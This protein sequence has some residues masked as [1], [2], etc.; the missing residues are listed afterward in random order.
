MFY[1]HLHC[2]YKSSYCS[3]IKDPVVSRNAEWDL[4]DWFPLVFQI[5]FF[6]MNISWNFLSFSNCNNCCLWT[7]NS[8]NKIST[9]NVPYD[10]NWKC[11]VSKITFN[12]FFFSDLYCK[13]FKSWLICL[14][15]FKLTFLIFGEA[16]PSL[17][18]IAI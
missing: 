17:V 7:Q 12:K 3:S 6:M 2:L 5:R 14:T 16:I 11:A 15:V 8:W 9:P 18:S 10:A 4:I 13:S 1:A